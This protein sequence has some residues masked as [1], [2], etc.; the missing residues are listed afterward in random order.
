MII[1]Y[2]AP[3][4]KKLIIIFIDF[5]IDYITHSKYDNNSDFFDIDIEIKKKNSNN[6]KIYKFLLKL[7][8]LFHG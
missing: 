4:T 7:L 3:A 1:R 8:Q 2:I 5:K 6:V